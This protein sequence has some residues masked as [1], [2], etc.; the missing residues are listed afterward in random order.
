M[1]LR[2]WPYHLDMVDSCTVVFV[3]TLVL[4]VNLCIA[5]ETGNESK[6]HSV[7][8]RSGKVNQVW[9]KAVRKGLPALEM[10]DLYAELK[11]HDEMMMEHKRTRSENDDGTRDAELADRLHEIMA[12]FSLGRKQENPSFDEVNKSNLKHRFLEDPNLDKLWQTAQKYGKFSDDELSALETE[13]QHHRR[14][15]EELKMLNSELSEIDDMSDNSVEKQMKMQ[16]RSEKKN[17]IAEMYGDIQEGYE[18]LSLKT[19]QKTLS[20]KSVP[21]T[22]PRVNALWEEA[23]KGNFS[24]EELDSIK[25]ELKH[26]QT[27]VEKHLFFR[28]QLKNSAEKI[29][30]HGGEDAAPQKHMDT[31]NHLQTK[32]Q[33]LAV[34]V[35]KLH[36]Q[37][38]KKLSSGS[39]V[40][41]EL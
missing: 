28:E 11:H 41:G 3:I 22:E 14:K 40:H 6:R 17:K 15:L 36:H 16:E 1:Y 29:S 25:E 21:F 12:K 37:L 8:F 18:R 34:K 2:L 30:Y 10:T 39:K 20:A 23:K 35:K 4:A 32:V 19:K 13:F 26:F 31:H 9:E 5:A 33:D 38:S 7:K 24:K 27:R